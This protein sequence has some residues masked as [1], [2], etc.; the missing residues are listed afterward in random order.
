MTVL[1]DIVTGKIASKL[2]YHRE[3]VRDC[4]WH[5]HLPMLVTTSFDGSVVE[6]DVRETDLD[7]DARGYKRKQLPRPGRDQL[8]D[9]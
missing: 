1:V 2:E 8:E 3:V 7:S 6:W 4:H 5:P 9:Y